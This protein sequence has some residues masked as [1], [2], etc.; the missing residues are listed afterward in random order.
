[1]DQHS[2]S[3]CSALLV[4]E[5]N[6]AQNLHKNTGQPVLLILNTGSPI[7]YGVT[8]LE[9]QYLYCWVLY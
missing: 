4:N 5:H 3:G 8:I 2:P 1:M 7:L 6:L 9:Y